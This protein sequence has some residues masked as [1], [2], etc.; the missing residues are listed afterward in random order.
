[1]PRD[2]ELGRRGR[3]SGL[4]AGVT[5]GAWGAGCASGLAVLAGPAWAQVTVTPI[6]A[7]DTS[8]AFGPLLTVDSEF[9]GFAN[10]PGLVVGG[11]GVATFMA[12]GDLKPTV[13]DNQD[14]WGVFRRASGGGGVPVS[15]FATSLANAPGFGSPYAGGTLGLFFAS[16]VTGPSG[17]TSAQLPV[18]APPPAGL[19]GSTTE[20][21]FTDAGGVASLI[22]AN[23][24][25]PLPGVTPG[26]VFRGLLPSAIGPFS[27][28][29]VNAAGRT[30]FQASFADPGSLGVVAGTGIWA[31]GPTG[32]VK[33]VAR[34]DALPGRPGEVVEQA[35]AGTV[36][37]SGN[38]RAVFIGNSTTIPS[39]VGASDGTTF[40]VLMTNNDS[41]LGAVNATFQQVR[42]NDGGDV[43]VSLSSGLANALLLDRG[44][45]FTTLA[46]SGGPNAAAGPGA[47]F[48]GEF[49]QAAL[50]GGGHVAF[51]TQTQLADFSTVDGVYRA[52][53]DGVIR[54]VAIGGQ[55]APG[56]PAGSTFA[57]FSAT[58]NEPSINALGQMVFSAVVLPPSGDFFEAQ[59]VWYAATP[60]A[61]GTTRLDVIF[62]S[63]QPITLPGYTP[64]FSPTR[65]GAVQMVAATG[66]EDGGQVSLVALP[67]EA[68]TFGRAVFWMNILDDPDVGENDTQVLV[69]VDI[70]GGGNAPGCAPDINAD[71]ILN[72]FDIIAFF[73]AFGSGDVGVADFA[74]A[75]NPDGVLNVFDILAFFAAFGAGC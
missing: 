53:P 9:T 47:V 11:D 55:P 75:G 70:A 32:L 52:D 67:R 8:G 57:P 2:A 61:G 34:G 48:A 68:P 17:V 24:V 6:A 50:G 66:D 21:L 15:T 72:I 16:L 3:S 25:T 22:A 1:M 44:S 18:N 27:A 23:G 35:F 38:G 46:L 37:W 20:G 65:L 10:F 31:T 12:G 49:R 51:R 73:G 7:L 26:A 74:P 28:V 58:F 42:Q 36:A 60:L 40:S 71:G 54:A 56:M 64:G 45:G 62:V 30:M 19:L 4:S 13:A 41:P 29:R 33:L 39:F 63:G 14:F 5:V 59:S 69:S 43:L